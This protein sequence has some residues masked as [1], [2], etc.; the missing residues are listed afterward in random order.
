MNGLAPGGYHIVFTPDCLIGA[1]AFVPQA[2]T[3]PVLVT[4]GT[5]TGGVGATL[6]A[7]GGIAGTVQVSGTPVAGVCVIAYPS[8]GGLAPLV[9]RTTADGSYQVTGLAPGSYDVEFT[10]G[11]GATTYVTQWYNGASSRSGATPVT[12]TS[13]TVTGSIDAH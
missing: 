2:L 8:A 12:V 3:S 13:G 9:A 7:D 5:T 6:A 4:A 1:G 11:C 10:A